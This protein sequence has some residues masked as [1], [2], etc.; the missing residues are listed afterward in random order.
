[1]CHTIIYCK[2]LEQVKKTD[3]LVADGLIRAAKIVLAKFGLLKKIVSDAGVIFISGHF[4]QFFR[5]LNI[6]KAIMSS[7]QH[8]SNGPMEACMKSVN[9]TIKNALIR[10]MTLT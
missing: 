4:K 7:Y 5:Q 8:Q 10:I 2:L 9:H 3:D 6:D 1:M